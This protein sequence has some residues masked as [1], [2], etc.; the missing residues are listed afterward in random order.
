MKNFNYVVE[1]RGVCVLN[2]EFIHPR[3][4]FH[5]GQAFRWEEI[6]KNH[7]ILVAL[8]RVIEVVKEDRNLCLMNTTEEDFLNLWINYF[9]LDTNYEK[10]IKTLSK[11]DPVMKKATEFGKGIRILKQEPFETF[12]TFIISSNNNIKRIKGS[13]EKIARG[14]GKTIGE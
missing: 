7:F 12:I 10:I 8:E 6:N 5:C 13:I 9:D 3:D 1:K 14:Y 11:D 2:Q 4:L